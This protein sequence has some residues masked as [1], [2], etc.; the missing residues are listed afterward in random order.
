MFEVLNTVTFAEQDGR[1]ALTNRARVVKWTAEAAPYL[2]GME[3]RW[4][5]SLERFEAFLAKA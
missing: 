1:T 5:E 2:A 3:V 4:T